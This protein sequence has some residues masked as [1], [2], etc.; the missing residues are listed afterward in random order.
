MVMQPSVQSEE[1]AELEGVPLR[2]VEF[3]GEAGDVLFFHPWLFHN[4]SPNCRARPRLAL[5]QT[6]PTRAG[7]K[8]YERPR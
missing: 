5:G 7:L 2:V 3:T 1:G 8:I 4:A 6:L